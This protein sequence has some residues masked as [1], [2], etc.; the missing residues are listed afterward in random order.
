MSVRVS[1][2]AQLHHVMK[3]LKETGNKGLG[4]GM[5]AGFR[6]AAMPLGPAVAAEVPKAMPSGY[7]PVLS[8]SLQF[9][10]QVR[11]F[12]YVARAT[13]RVYGDG[14]QE[15][16]DVPSLNR[17]VLRHPLF[18]NRERWVDQKVRKG[19]V[20]RPVDRLGVDVRREMN[21][22][23]DQVADKIARG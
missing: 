7:A 20:D 22:V 18:G 2:S 15:R 12:K 10:T 16:R 5:A 17:G 14:Q 23:V 21:K 19:F 3:V 6:L 4:K 13:W 1:G 11:A 9:R 8:R